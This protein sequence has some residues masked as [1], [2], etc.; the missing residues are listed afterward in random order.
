[1]RELLLLMVV[2]VEGETKRKKERMRKSE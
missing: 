1:V 2:L